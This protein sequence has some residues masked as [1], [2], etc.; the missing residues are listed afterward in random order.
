MS[1]S[2]LRCQTE[3]EEP[4]SGSLLYGS[5]KLGLS[6]AWL[7]ASSA[8]AGEQGTWAFGVS[9]PWS[10]ETSAPPP[11]IHFTD[12]PN[13]SFA[14]SQTL[15]WLSLCPDRQGLMASP[16]LMKEAPPSAPNLTALNWLGLKT[17]VLWYQGCLRF[18]FSSHLKYKTNQPRSNEER[19]S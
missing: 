1:I 7:L 12:V 17:K 6:H 2:G 9:S 3:A 11:P 14:C 10:L 8:F 13:S 5:E 16:S 4:G 15:Y 18:S 19:A